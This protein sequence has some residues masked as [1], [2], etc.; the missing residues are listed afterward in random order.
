VA[1]TLPE[2]RAVNYAFATQLGS[3]VYDVSGRTV[4]IYRLPFA[5]TPRPEARG[6]LGVRV[7]IP[8]TIGFVDFKPL[9][10]AST[11]LPDH[12]DTGSIVPGV[13]LRIVL[14]ENWM[15]MPS[16]EFGIATDRSSEATTYIS[17]TGVRSVADFNAGNFGLALGNEA[18]YSRVDP[19]N[20]EPADAFF[21]FE[22]CLEAR[23]G[24][25]FSIHGLE[26][27]YRLYALQDLYFGDP[28]SRFGMSRP[29]AW[30]ISTRPA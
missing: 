6:R 12:L 5:F 9:D 30:T 26:A 23:H 14:R 8:V 28:P 10:V 4:Q 27:D 7:M 16:A 18:L 11:G 21:S 20:D 13:E 22:T 15:L 19:R 25:G 3:G 17:S 24:M 29:P 1:L 2:E